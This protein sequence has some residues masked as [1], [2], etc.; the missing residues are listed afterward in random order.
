[1]VSSGEDLLELKIAYFGRRVGSTFRLIE[2]IEEGREGMKAIEFV[3]R[4][5][6]VSFLKGG[7][8]GLTLYYSNN[9]LNQGCFSIE[10][11]ARDPTCRTFIVS[12]VSYFKKSGIVSMKQAA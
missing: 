11:I 6:Y 8:C 1:M 10:F 3:V 5:H 2:T 7:G 12:W 9:L 4:G